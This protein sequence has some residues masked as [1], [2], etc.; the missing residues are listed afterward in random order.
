MRKVLVALLSVCLLACFVVSVSARDAV[1]EGLREYRDVGEFTGVDPGLVDLYN[2]AAVD[3]YCI[4]WYTFE[5]MSW[6]GF[7]QVDRT[8][9]QDTFFHADDFG[10]LGGGTFGRLV[11]IEG[12]MSA[13]CGA[14]PGTDLYMCAWEDAPGYGDNWNQS[15][16]TTP[17]PFVGALYI[18]YHGVFDSEA[19]YDFTH[20]EY[21]LGDDNWVRVESWDGIIDTIATHEMLLPKA[22]TKLRFHFVSDGAWSDEDGRG[23]SDGGCVIDSITIYDSSTPDPL[24]DFEDFEDWA[25]M[26]IK[27]PGSKWHGDVEAPYGIFGGLYSNLM[28]KDPCGDNWGTQVVFFI[29]SPNPSASYPGLYDTPF[30]KGPGGI[31]NPCQYELI[32]SPEI[33]MTKYSSNLNNVQDMDIPTEDLPQLGGAILRFTVYRDLPSKNNVFY[34]WHVRNLDPITGCPGI[35][36]DRNY[37]YYGPD[38]DYIFGGFDVSDLVGED[39]IQIGLGCW[40]YCDAFYAE[41][42]DCLYHTPS[43]WID[44][45]RFYRYKT[46]GPQWSYRGL[47]MFQDNFPENELDFDSWVRADAAD[48]KAGADDDYFIPGDS[49][50]FTCTSPLGGGI[51]GGGTTGGG[52]VYMFVRV[53]DVYDTRPG[54]V[55][56]PIAGASLEGTYGTYVSD[57]GVWTKI[58]CDTA[59]AQLHNILDDQWMVDL[60]DSLLT[61]GYMVEYYLEAWDVTGNR[62]TL[63]RYA[64]E[65]QYFEFTCLPTGRSTVLFVDDFH[66]RGSWRGTVEEYWDATFEAVIDPD[67]QPDVYDVNAPS[68]MVGNGVASRATLSQLMYNDVEEAGYKI[69]VW[70]AGDLDVATIGDGSGNG[71]KA[72]D[73]TLLSNWLDQSGNDVGLL[74]CGDDIAYDLKEN[75]NSAE[76]IGLMSTW[77]GVD[78]VQDSYFEATGGRVAGGVISPNITGVSTGIFWHGGAYD[79]LIAFGGCPIINGFDVIATTNYGAEALHY[80][81]FESEDYVAGIQSSQTNSGLA[82]ARTMWLGFS[83]QVIRDDVIAAPIDRNE[84]FADIYSWFQEIP[85]GDITDA[86]PTPE[87]R[88]SLGQNYPNP[89]NPNTWIKFEIRK[90]GHVSLKIYN[91]AGQLV[92]TLINDVM[93]AGEHTADWNGTNNAGIKVASGVYFYS[94][95]ADEFK[96]T[97]KMVLLR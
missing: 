13:W 23:D 41:P 53:T 63:P 3:T 74:V 92:K 54:G 93:N 96:S 18:S 1:K 71:D 86:D 56:P 14:R 45:A 48:D 10:G 84:L 82:T 22:E 43:P 34:V 27:G 16:M 87:A 65:G 11:A 66:G 58:Q 32:V 38:M 12:D 49:I 40:D 61:R 90:K 25:V 80:P 59:K 85:I 72:D 62:S 95:E 31:T 91:V 97:K 35:W 68:S 57:D 83:W 19:T 2:S 9:Q 55:K 36:Q 73:C 17:F 75:L 64:D 89:F 8:A 28:D 5:T 24:I 6:Q 50:A 47:E 88:N 26:A 42:G 69:I 76:A 29:G 81:Q 39:P 33:D 4:V 67:R 30:C 51:R 21:D 37:V 79:E 94:I 7:T 60:N 20:V 70:D 44:N 15:L 52:E 46:S 77:C 78:Y